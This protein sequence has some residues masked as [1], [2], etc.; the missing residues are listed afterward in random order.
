M[1][2]GFPLNGE[3]FRVGELEELPLAMVELDDDEGMMLLSGSPLWFF[4]GF[5][6]L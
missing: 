5:F 6:S 3:V 4:G 2:T 1:L